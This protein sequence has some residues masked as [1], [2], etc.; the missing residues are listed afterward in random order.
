MKIRATDK[1]YQGKLKGY[2]PL[3][4]G[5]SILLLR[6]RLSLSELGAF[7][8]YVSVTPWDKK[9]NK[10][11][12]IPSNSEMEAI[13]GKDSS[14]W[15][16]YTKKLTGLGLFRQRTDGQYEIPLYWRFIAKYATKLAGYNHTDLHAYYSV[17][18]VLDEDMHQDSVN[19]HDD[20]TFSEARKHREYLDNTVKSS[21]H[22]TIKDLSKET[23]KKG[24]ELSKKDQ[25]AP[26]P[27]SLTLAPSYQNELNNCQSCGKTIS[28]AVTDYSYKEYGEA[29]CF[30]CIK[31]K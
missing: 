26:H 2:V 8:T 12:V 6:E 19:L 30:N 7:T 28:Q 15:S 18:H 5:E 31:G 16:R 22:S 14:Q 25:D 24:K 10:Y 20:P 1:D 21:V 29:L 3:S 4:R 17:L 11:G 13:T 27:R 23:V 9:N